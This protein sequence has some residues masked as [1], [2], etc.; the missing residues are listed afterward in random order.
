MTISLKAKVE[1]GGTLTVSD[2]PLPPGQ[3]VALTIVAP[4]PVTLSADRY[5]LRGTAYR[6]DEP[7]APAIDPDDW[8]ANA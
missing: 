4:D 1:A 2:L 6:Y 3:E 5:P 8:E 7:F